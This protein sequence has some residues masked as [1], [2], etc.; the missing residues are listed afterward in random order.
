[1]H[2]V[3]VSTKVT[4]TG[5]FLLL[6]KDGTSFSDKSHLSTVPSEVGHREQIAKKLRHVENIL[7]DCWHQGTFSMHRDG[8]VPNTSGLNGTVIA[9]YDVNGA[10]ERRVMVELVLVSIH[11]V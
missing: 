7:Q 3:E 2:D 1:V 4:F 5:N 8:D 10:G 11:V 9:K 6:I